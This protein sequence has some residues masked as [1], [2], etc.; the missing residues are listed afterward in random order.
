MNNATKQLGIFLLGAAAGAAMGILLAPDK[1]KNTRNRIIKASNDAKHRFDDE[2][3]EL[4]RTYNKKLDKNLEHVKE[5]V[6]SMK[7]KLSVK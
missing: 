1:G 7:K 2:V 3:E 5:G 4:K 6:D